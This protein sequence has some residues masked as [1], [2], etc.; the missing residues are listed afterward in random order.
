MLWLV[1]LAYRT[2]G[3]W[4]CEKSQHVNIS[5]VINKFDY[6]LFGR[7]VLVTWGPAAPTIYTVTLKMGLCV[8]PH[9]RPSVQF[10]L[11]S[12]V[13][14]RGVCTVKMVVHLH[15]SVWHHGQRCWLMLKDRLSDSVITRTRLPNGT[16]ARREWSCKLSTPPVLLWQLHTAQRIQSKFAKTQQYIVIVYWLSILR[17]ELKCLCL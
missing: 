3:C 17:S 11:L 12:S 2:L 7:F 10:K 8:C 16:M 15:G 14:K 6:F 1:E 9:T 5:S 13:S 4:C